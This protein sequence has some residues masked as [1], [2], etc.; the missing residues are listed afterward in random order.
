MSNLLTQEPPLQVL[1][2]LA[3]AI[4]LNEAIVLQQVHYLLNYATTTK[5]DKKWVY[6]NYDAWQAKHFR[7]WS[8]ETV[9]RTFNSLKNQG[10]LLCEKLRKNERNQTNFYTVNYDAV[11]KLN[12]VQI[13]STLSKS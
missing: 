2:S 11:A 7:F 9:K 10:L 1:P 5:D 6:N 12:L 3:V 4:G 13:D 8:V